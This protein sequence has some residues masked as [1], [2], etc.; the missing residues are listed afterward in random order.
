MAERGVV[1]G[2]QAI[3][4]PAGVERRTEAGLFQI[5]A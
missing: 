1:D 5:P 3:P 2:T 4:G